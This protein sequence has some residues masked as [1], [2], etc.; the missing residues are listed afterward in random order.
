[1]KFAGWI[2]L[3]KECYLGGV[4]AKDSEDAKKKFNKMVKNNFDVE[5]TLGNTDWEE[6]IILGCD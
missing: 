5:W 1:M 2:K 4:K 6:E 3:S